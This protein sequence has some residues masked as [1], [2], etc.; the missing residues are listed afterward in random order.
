[1]TQ[2]KGQKECTG[3]GRK[4]KRAKEQTMSFEHTVIVALGMIIGLL[5]MILH[6]M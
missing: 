3:H 5:F 2:M 1:M 6:K 4:E